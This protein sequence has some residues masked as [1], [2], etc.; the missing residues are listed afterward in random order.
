MQNTRQSN[1]YY[2][3][4]EVNRSN[5]VG[6]RRIS[7]ERQ[8]DGASFETQEAEI[9][10]YCQENK[11]N[12]LKIYE[13]EAKSGM[14]TVG[15]DGFLNLI[16]EIQPGNFIIVHELSRFCRDQLDTISYFRDLVRNKGCTFISITPHIDSR[17]STSDLMVGI[18]SSIFQEESRRTGER[19]SANM[20]RLS[21]E[22]KLLCRPPFGYVHDPKTRRYIPDDQQQDV[23]AK[24]KTMYLGNVNQAEIA[25][26]LNAA[27]FG[28]VLNNNKTKKIENIK[29]TRS[30]VNII[31][32]NYGLIKDKKSPE[33]TYPQR[34]EAWNLSLV[35]KRNK[36]KTNAVSLI[37]S[38]ITTSDNLILEIVG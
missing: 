25:R 3:Q 38:Q 5:A 17:D 37:N 27:G 4:L 8:I 23:V 24:I 22:G 36:N 16:N 19:V 28:P 29:F 32:Q 20:Q 21:K 26:R 30:T 31:L 7:D 13:D 35:G 10:K 6:Y 18:Y 14:T 12:L 2:S 34:V 33:F 1:N 11:L 15:R 9:R